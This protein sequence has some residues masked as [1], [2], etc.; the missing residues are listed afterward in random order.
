MSDNALI[1]IDNVPEEMR[2][3]L[4]QAEDF[5]AVLADGG[6]TSRRI[7]IRGGVFRE[8]INGKEVSEWDGRALN[9]VII[10][11]GQKARQFYE[12][13]WKEGE[14]PVPPT[15]WSNNTNDGVPAADVPEEQRQA[16]RCADCPQNIKG[17]GDNDSRACRYS[18]RIAVVLEEDLGQEEPGVYQVSIPAASLF[19][20][21]VAGKMPLQAYA[22]F[23]QSHK[24]PCVAI[25]TEMRLDSSASTPKLT[26]KAQRALNTAELKKVI[27]LQKAPETLQAITFSVSQQDG[28]QSLPAPTARAEAAPITVQTSTRRAPVVEDPAPTPAAEPEPEQP[29]TTRRRAVAAAEPTEAPTVRSTGRK[30]VG[31]QPAPADVASVIEAWDDE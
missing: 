3:L 24:T 30:P 20:D 19:G 17:S 16:T 8:V 28:V 31:E 6:G 1:S 10:N 27:P 12:G 29:K 22:R 7:S 14:K 4:A 26:F 9:V 13:K 2:A 5:G 23:L 21:G 11:A 25:V 18:Q 15:C